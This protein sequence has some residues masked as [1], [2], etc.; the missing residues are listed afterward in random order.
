MNRTKYGTFDA[1]LAILLI[2]FC[3]AL[4][5]ACAVGLAVAVYAGVVA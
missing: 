5:G 2:I 1:V 4:A 3:V